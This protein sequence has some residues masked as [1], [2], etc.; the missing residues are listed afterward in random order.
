[1]STP[2]LGTPKSRALD[3]IQQ[4]TTALCDRNYCRIAVHHVGPPSL[5]ENITFWTDGWQTVILHEY[6]QGMGFELYI[7]ATD[8]N[9]IEAVI[10]AIPVGNRDAAVRS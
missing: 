9:S 6:R 4:I 10:D 5:G 7:A 8:K 1:M 3:R 2:L